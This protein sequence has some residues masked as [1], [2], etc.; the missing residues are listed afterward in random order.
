MGRKI[1]GEKRDTTKPHST[2]RTRKALQQRK[3]PTT[4]PKKNGFRNVEGKTTTTQPLLEKC[5]TGEKMQKKSEKGFPSTTNL[6]KWKFG[7]GNLGFLI[8]KYQISNE[9]PQTIFRP[10][11]KKEEQ[12]LTNLKWRDTPK[13]N[14]KI[15]FSTKTYGSMFF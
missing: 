10:K 13:E 5:H 6:K 1:K 11:I 9:S 12:Y 2:C 15:L 3:H 14:Q 7:H 8:E 4:F